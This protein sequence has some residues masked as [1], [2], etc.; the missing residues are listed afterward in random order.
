MGNP[1]P[2]YNANSWGCFSPV[3]MKAV[4]KLENAIGVIATD[5]S[6][7]SLQNLCT[8]YIDKGI[9]VIM[10]ATVGMTSQYKV[11]TWVTPGGEP[12]SYNNKLHCLLLVGYDENNYFFNDPM[13]KKKQ[14][15]SK[16]S[17]EA[18]YAAL[19]KQAIVITKGTSDGG[20]AVAP[21]KDETIQKPVE[22]PKK[23]SLPDEKVQDPIDLSTGAHVIDHTLMTVSG[24][25]TLRFGIS[26]RSNVLTEGSAGKGWSHNFEKKI[27]DDGDAPLYL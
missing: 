25:Q 7:T 22:V 18:A 17:V 11:H 1:F 15:Y 24:A 21:P 19:G 13:T 10:W 9:P 23:P 12:I 16:A 6:G 27:A 8:N 4:G 5:V 20:T 3:I 26:Y 14:G 2:G